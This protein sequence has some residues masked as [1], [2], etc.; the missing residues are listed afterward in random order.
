MEEKAPLRGNRLAFIYFLTKAF[1]MPIIDFPL[2]QLKVYKPPLTRRSDFKRFWDENVKLADEQ[3]L[4]HVLKKIEYPVKKLE[5]YLLSFEGFMDKTPITCWF[6]KPVGRGPFPAL[7]IPH[8]YGWHRGTVSDYLGWVFQDIVVLAIDIRGQFGDTPDFAKYPSGSITGYMTKGI[9]DKNTY[10]YRYVYMD[11][12]RALKVL[13]Q[14]DCVDENRVGVTG[15]SQ[16]GGLTLVVSA[17]GSKIAL[18]MPEI[19]FLC[20]FERA[21]EVAASDPYLEIPRYLKMHPD[22]SEKVF[23][24]LSYFDA[25]NFAPDINCPILMSV[26]LTDTV[27]PPSTIFAAFNHLASKTKELAIYPGMGHECLSVHR[28]KM[29]EWVSKHLLQ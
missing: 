29:I 3:P 18:S 11:C 28:E 15:A 17:L 25:M 26:G 21:V 9:L 23:E 22:K 4:N 12:L 14:M 13:Y 7:L 20:H 2:E 10:Y 5:A 1:N 8:G 16:G 19:P 24:T 6:L 27:C